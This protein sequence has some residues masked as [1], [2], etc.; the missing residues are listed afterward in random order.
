MAF[1]RALY[2]VLPQRLLSGIAGW[3]GR[4]RLGALTT[5][6]IRWF[7]RHYGVDLTE[8]A[9][10][11]V[12]AYASFNAF[13]TRA[14]RTG[15]RH[16]PE[17]PRAIASPVDGAVSAAGLI[18]GSTLIQA[19]GIHYSVERLIGS[20]PAAYEGGRFATLYLR[21]HDYHRVHVPV[22]G[23]LVAV[24]HC[25]GRLWPVRPWAVASVPGLFAANDRVVLAFES[26]AGRYA[27]VMI[28]ALMVGGLET[29]VTGPIRRTA[30]EPACWNLEAAPREFARGDEIGRFNFGSTVIL[31]FSRDR[32]TFDAQALAL[33]R[34]VRL[35]ET[36][37]GLA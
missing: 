32:T 21:P 36:L 13:F 3:V 20:D 1:Q 35:G 9:E 2:G 25:P 14:L 26:E 18:E 19:K 28:G 24:R 31:L 16:W 11:S 17:D 22:R 29:L 30:H 7:A 4:R 6:F 10:P 33:G 37:G 23:R 5:G 34:E 27:L 8:A 15:A 12:E